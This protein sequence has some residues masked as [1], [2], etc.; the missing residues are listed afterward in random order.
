MALN[1]KKRLTVSEK[2]T[3][4]LLEVLHRVLNPLEEQAERRAAIRLVDDDG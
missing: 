1:K 3:R 4:E 2:E